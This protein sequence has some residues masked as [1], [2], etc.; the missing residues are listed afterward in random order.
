MMSV[1]MAGA[2]RANAAPASRRGATL[3]GKQKDTK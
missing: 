1:G 3:G 2:A